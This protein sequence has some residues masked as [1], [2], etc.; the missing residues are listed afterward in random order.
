MSLSISNT[1]L[2]ARFFMDGAA[3]AR[4]VSQGGMCLSFATNPLVNFSHDVF[5]FLGD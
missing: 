3:F 4:L 5:H 2:D 1:F